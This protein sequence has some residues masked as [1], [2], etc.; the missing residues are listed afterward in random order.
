MSFFLM[1]KKTRWRILYIYFFIMFWCLGFDTYS[2]DFLFFPRIFYKNSFVFS[3]TFQSKFIVYCFFCFC[4]FYFHHFVNVFILFHL[5]LNLKFVVAFWFIF[6]A[7]L[8]F[9]IFIIFFYFGFFVCFFYSNPH[10][11]SI[12]SA[13][14][15]TTLIM[16]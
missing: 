8:T 5:N 9:I 15:L 6:I 2:Y 12:Y 14:G 11:F 13:F 16:V 7:T 3:F 10:D 1:C 4:S